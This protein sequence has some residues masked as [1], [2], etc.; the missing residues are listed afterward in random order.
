MVRYR[1]KYVLKCIN[2]FPT[3]GGVSNTYSPRATLTAKSV[4]YRKYCKI[5]FGSYDQAI[6]ENKPTN[7]TTPRILGVIYQRELD[8]LKGGFEVLNLLTGKIIYRSKVIP[9]QIT[10]KIIDRVEALSKKDGIISPLK[11]K[12]RNYGAIHKN[13]DENDDEDVSIS[14]EDNEY[15]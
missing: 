4:N 11:F 14:G 12:L 15:R 9:I 1:V 3:K 8:T 2:I 13:D 7:T 5:I 10:Q 6:H